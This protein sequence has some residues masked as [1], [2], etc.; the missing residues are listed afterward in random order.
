MATAAA[1]VNSIARSAATSGEAKSRNSIANNFDS[2]LLLLTTQ[3][4]N[5]SPLDPLDTNQ[6]TQQLVQFA[7]VE[8]QLRTNDTLKAL[9]TNAQTSTVSNAASF[10]GLQVTADGASTRLTDEGASWTLTAPKAVA[11]ATLTI[12]DTEGNVVATSLRPLAAG[13]QAFTW[14][15]RTS[16]GQKAPAGDYTITVTGVDAGGASVSIKTEIQGRVDSVDVSG[17]ETI[18]AIGKLRVPLANVKAVSRPVGQ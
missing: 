1:A 4:K 17:S 15:G 12:K 11:R 18:L 7:S 13:S 10:V 8:Q 2:F 5:Q 16:T 9:L 3:L 6:F 14:D